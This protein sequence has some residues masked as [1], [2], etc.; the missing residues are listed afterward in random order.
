MNPTP[1]TLYYGDNLPILRTY[2]PAA[3][4]DLIYL[5]PPFNSNRSYNVLFKDE[6][7]R[8]S[9]AQITAFEDSWH[10]G[11]ST[12]DL[13]HELLGSAPDR[14]ARVLAALIESLGR[15]NQICAYLV[16]MAARL[17]EL[18]RALKPTGSLYLHCDDSA[19]H[20]LKLILD[21]IFGPE[22]YRNH[23]SWKRAIA[24]NDPARFG[25]IQDHILLYSR[26]DQP[27]W[28]GQAIATAKTE[29]QLEAAYPSKDKRGRYRSAD[30]TGAGVTPGSPSSLP[31]HGY[32]VAALGRHWSAPKT[33]KYAEYI[34][35]HFIPGY[36]AIP[37]I[38]ER[39][40]AL[41][42]AG[43]IHHPKRG[44]W[45]GLKRYAAADTGNPPQDLLLEPSGFTNYNKQRGEHLGFQTQKPRALL[46]KFILA[47]CPP[48]GLVLD[49][50]CGCGTAI[51]AAHQLGRR[52]AGIDITHLSVALMKYRLRDRYDLRPGRDYEVIGEPTTLPGAQQLASDDRYQFQW[53]VL[54]LVSAKPLGAPSDSHRG[55]KGADR[56]IDGVINFLGDGGKAERAL[57]QV[58]SGGVNS[59]D[60]RDLR[61]TL[62]RENAALAA[63]ITLESPSKPMQTEAL[64]A[65]FYETEAWGNFPRLQLLT[66]EDLLSGEQQLE[67]PREY[68]TFRRAPRAKRPA[69]STPDQKK[70]RLG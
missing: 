45:P 15:T 58:K 50:F 39:L 49:P 41:D 27:Y 46:E 70:M 6:S 4:V 10:W 63:F 64:A 62:E 51:D 52:W 22:N 67:M 59:G 31:W 38:H 8:D 40:E 21:T 43:L 20:Y 57:I 32:D 29:E 12:E 26:A 17:I 28:N 34:E 42:A 3:S 55:K 25:R 14:I 30:L 68:G 5:D 35:R 19:S 11:R 65:G 2:F 60:I 16:M 37:G 53:W 66:I 47:S 13:Y 18:H 36:R 23:L 24:H 54:S 7:G 1:N 69:D 44:K 61:G 48:D 9:E 56:G 33:G